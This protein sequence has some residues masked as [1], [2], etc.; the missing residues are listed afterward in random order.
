MPEKQMLI[1]RPLHKLACVQAE[2][3]ATQLFVA[4]GPYLNLEIGPLS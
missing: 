1:H 3:P 4:L 2:Y